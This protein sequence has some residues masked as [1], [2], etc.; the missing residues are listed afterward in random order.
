MPSFI[1]RTF[2]LFRVRL[3]YNRGGRARQRMIAFAPPYRRG[4]HLATT[5]IRA[6]SAVMADIVIS[7]KRDPRP[8]TDADTARIRRRRAAVRASLAIEG[9]VL[10][11]EEERILDQ[12][13]AEGLSAEK[14]RARVWAYGQ[15]LRRKRHAAAG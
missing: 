10:T 3:V 12:F 9:L 5:R 6:I 2:G 13:E 15:S 8:P 7:P 1:A 11:A 14:R 4:L